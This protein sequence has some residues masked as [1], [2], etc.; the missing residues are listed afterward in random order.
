MNS[1][2]SRLLVW[3][4]SALA[5]V[6][7]AASGMTYFEAREDVND[8]FDYQLQQMAL[9]LEHRPGVASRISRGDAEDRVEE[10]DFVTEI[11]NRRG[12]LIFTSHPRMV[13]PRAAGHGYAMHSWRDSSWRTYETSWHGL[14]IQVAQPMTARAEMAAAM[15]LRILVPVLLLIP[16]LG[17]VIWISVGRGLLPL[18]EIGAA[19]A[20]RSPSAMSPLSAAH[21]PVEVAPMVTA[22]NDLLARLSMAMQTQRQ[23]IADAAH[24][25]RTPLTA[26]QLQLQLVE[27][28]DSP[29]ERETALAELRSG[30][31]RAI[32][33]I[34]QLLALARAEPQAI[35]VASGA[36][37]ID[38]LARA[39]VA[40]YAALAVDKGV[41][42]GITR[43]EPAMVDADAE[44]LRV[45]LGNLV[46][47]A[48]RYTPSGGR[49]DLSVSAIAADAVLEVEDNGPGIS[50][51]HLSRIFDRFYRQPGTQVSGS[52]LGLAIVKNIV[53][54][55]RGRITLGVGS[56][57]QGLKATVQFALASGGSSAAAG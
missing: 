30:I 8:L 25:L 19:L 54:R 18:K 7:I 51:E 34:Q 11:W 17:V 38:D 6:G 16:F 48:I 21:L 56:G 15:A 12:Q 57:G 55:H 14:T 42:L 10:S 41:D 13:L 1:I 43:L 32:H 45:M 40:D 23:F 50:P 37:P 5:L 52:G 36:V 2:R 39:V 53:E 28:A 47:N 31:G 20:A 26:I 29:A 33:L 35:L 4:L 44:S 22:V 46:D 24:E 27:R 49:I 3:M 9:S